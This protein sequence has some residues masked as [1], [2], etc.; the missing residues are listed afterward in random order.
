VTIRDGA[1][2]NNSITASGD[3]KASAGK[4]LIYVAGTGADSFTGG[5]ENDVVE[6]GATAVGND[7][8]TGGGGIN[9]LDLTSAGTF[10]LSNVGNFGAI[11][12]A[13]GNN[14]VTLTDKTLSGGSVTIKAGASGNNTITAAG[15]TVASAG[16]TLTYIAGPGTDSFT[17]GFENDLVKVG[18][19]AVG[20]D[21]LTGGNGTNT[22]TLT[23]VG[24]VNLSGVSKFGAINLVAGNNTVT[25][26]DKT[27][28][29]GSVTI[30]AGASG[31]NT[32][33]AAGDTVAS[34]GRTLTYVAGPG[35]DK[36]TG[37]FEL[38]VVQVSA[39]A[40][41][42]DTLTGGRVSNKLTLT[43]TG[44]FG[45]TGVSKFGMINLAA[46][47]NMVTVADKTL[48]GGSVAIK[49]GVFKNGAGGDN[50]IVATGDTKASTGKML[51]YTAGS[52]ADMFTGGFENDVVKVS[53]QAVSGDILTGGSGTNTLNLTTAD[54]FT[55]NLAGVS[56]FGTIN[57]AAGNNSLTVADATLSGGSVMIKDGASGDNVI[58]AAGDT[59]AST[60]KTLTFMAGS[61]ADTLTGGFENDVFYAGGDTTMTG[62][63]GTNEFVFSAAGN[64][65]ITDFAGS[66]SVGPPPVPTLTS[67]VSFNGTTNGEYPYAGLTFDAA[68]NLFGT[69][70]GVGEIIN[71]AGTVFEIPKTAGKY[72]SA[73]TTLVSFNVTNGASPSGALIADAAGDLF[74]T[75]YDG[76][77]N[78][79]GTV[80][81]IAKT[82][83]SYAS[84]PTTL[85][86][87]S[88]A[89]GQFPDGGLIADA[90]GDLFGTTSA[91]GANG[92]GTV[93][94]IA[95]TS[96]SY[97]STPTT[98]VSFNGTNGKDP[99]GLI[100]DAAGDL[101]GTTEVGGAGGAGTVFEIP[102]NGGKYAGTPTTLASFNG[103]NGL[104]PYAGVIADA[105]GDLFGTTE[106]GLSTDGTVFELVNDGS[107]SYTLTTLVSFNGTDGRNPTGDLI[108]DDTGD[109][110][111]TIG[112][113]GARGDGAVFEIPFIA[114][115][116]ASTPTTLASFNGANGQF[117]AAGLIA[118]AAGNLFSTTPYGGSNG[119]G[120]VFELSGSGFV[121]APPTTNKIVFSNK[122]FNLKLSGAT[123]TPKPL[124]TS[125]FVSDNMG[126]FTAAK[127][128]FAY[129]MTNGELFYSASGTTAGEH[130]VATL[131]GAP[132]LSGSHLFYIT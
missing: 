117:P 29:G 128:R 113:V 102:F 14:T 111:G 48:S 77:A 7:V 114:G 112:F 106:G 85:V 41:G 52:G 8:L 33:T 4:T 68:G 37:G 110:F 109:L 26:A 28:S 115:S 58:S 43:T 132:M 12:L 70:Q 120:T 88:G 5:F 101:F 131:T 18:A 2:G 42:R 30:K 121:V 54:T 124:P 75:A 80:F 45:L 59:S 16:K 62:A 100:A 97:A 31:N 24:T 116:Y 73:P 65:T 119:V 6:V 71:E 130:L 91:G 46:G 44:T 36:F 125:L 17:G 90:A 60:G 21:I 104:D 79:D 82:S 103:T 72:A 99:G 122:G 63:G 83:G 40:V 13:A 96:G 93:F 57:L 84:T 47:D 94:E 35:T 118:D 92:N 105:A 23:R 34:A 74:G 11:N 3:T 22:L 66:I 32:I 27:L 123:S 78:S 89:N 98:L 15:D 108:L 107:G 9:T 56:K 50:T 39:A 95:K 81:E 20:R 61:G 25:V 76:G 67:L 53:A 127:Q 69:T 55:F 51:T 38:D 1:S 87:F 64:N 126:T 10:N 49:D 86:S 19:A 129:G